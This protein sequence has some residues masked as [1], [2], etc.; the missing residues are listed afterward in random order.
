MKY[1]AGVGVLHEHVVMAIEFLELE[2]KVPLM[3]LVK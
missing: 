3:R 1:H 2:S